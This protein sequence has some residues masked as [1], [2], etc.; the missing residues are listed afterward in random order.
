MLVMGR[1]CVG[2]GGGGAL[3]LT[4]GLSDTYGDLYDLYVH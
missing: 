4:L 1:G 2:G 3:A